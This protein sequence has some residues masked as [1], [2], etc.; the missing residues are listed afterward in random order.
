VIEYCFEEVWSQYEFDERSFLEYMRAYVATR[1]QVTQQ[2][3]HK[4]RRDTLS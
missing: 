1:P 3:R 2:I 4:A